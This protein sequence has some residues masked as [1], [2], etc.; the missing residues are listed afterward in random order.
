[1]TQP[2]NP[3]SISAEKALEYVCW[4][5]EVDKLFDVALGMYDFELVLMV[6]QK[7]QKD[8]KEYLPFLSELQQMEMFYQRYSI[9]MHLKRFKKAFFNLSQVCQNFY[10]KRRILIHKLFS[11]GKRYLF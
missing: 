9:D 2:T 5:A 10:F 6:A 1:M 7:S 11:Q 8:P 4:L 3:S